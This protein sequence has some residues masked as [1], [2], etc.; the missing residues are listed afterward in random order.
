MNC[1]IQREQRV[2]E[3]LQIN[4]RQML[5]EITS[6]LK[7]IPSAEYLLCTNPP[8]LHF[9]NHISFDPITSIIFAPI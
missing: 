7:I 2:K 1:Y 5:K 4:Q 8:A 9:T 6:A 3:N